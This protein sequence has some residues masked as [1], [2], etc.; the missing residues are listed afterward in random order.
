MNDTKAEGFLR[1][2]FDQA[3]SCAPCIIVIRHLDAFAQSTQAPEPG[4]G[5]LFIN[6]IGQRADTG[7]FLEPPLVTALE[8]L[9][10]D[11]YG[12]WR[13]FGYPVLVYGTTSEPG[14][15]PPPISACFKHEVEFEVSL[16]RPS[17]N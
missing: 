16:L 6:R 13:L 1:A 12:A 10:A 5:K 4:K 2:R 15:V 8:E 9:F 14:R 7:F 3:T 11:L 17:H